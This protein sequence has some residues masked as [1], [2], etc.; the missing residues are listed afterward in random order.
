MQMAFVMQP[1]PLGTHI[2][3]TFPVHQLLGACPIHCLKASTFGDGRGKPKDPKALL[4]SRRAII[5]CA[6]IGALTCV[7][8]GGAAPAALWPLARL[9][10]LRSFGGP[11]WRVSGVV[12]ASAALLR[13]SDCCFRSGGAR[14][15]TAR[16]RPPT[17]LR[18]GVRSPL[19]LP[20][21]PE[22]ATTLHD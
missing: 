9:D 6:E 12:I 5:L 11:R 22:A 16:P 18:S 1:I 21:V 14:L 8:A 3:G 20:G 10:V 13:L 7:F 17:R 19:P 15:P 2:L 4:L